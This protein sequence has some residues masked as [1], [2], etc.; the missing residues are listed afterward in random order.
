MKGL[1][2][3]YVLTYGGAAAS[4]FSPFVGLLVYVCF[5]IV[6]PEAMWYWS[7]PQGNYSRIVALAL[8][9]GWGVNGFGKWRLGRARAL[10]VAFACFWVWAAISTLW[11]KEQGVALEF[12]ELI[13][14]VF[15]P[16]LVG[17]TIIDSVQKLKLLAWVIMLSQAYVAFELNLIYYQGYNRLQEE[18]FAGMDNNSVAI[19]LVTCI[20]PAFFLGLQ[21]ERLWLKAVAL[22]GA[23]MMANAVLFSYS[24]GGMLALVITGLVSFFLLPK[25]PRHYIVFAAAVLV[26]IRLAGSQIV[27]RFWTS[28]NSEGS[29]DAS[30]ES[31][32]QLWTVCWDLMLKHPFGLGPSQFGYVASDY[33]F[34]TGKLAHSLWLQLG[35]ELGFVGLGFLSLFFGTCMVRLWPVAREKRSVPDPWLRVASRMVLASLVGFAVSAQFVSLTTLEVPYYIALVGAAALKLCSDGPDAARLPKGVSEGGG[36]A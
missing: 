25:K 16:F 31:R 23:S 5:A 33:G 35:A 13:A 15:L 6:K 26:L 10:I 18:G 1:L 24:R 20:W 9:A 2:F 34:P 4:L 14:K 19:A 36:A 3:T 32:L 12:V 27:E 28:F 11:A 17:I 29:R 30:A 8:L 22:A 21:T 7:V